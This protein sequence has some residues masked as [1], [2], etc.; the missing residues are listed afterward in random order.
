VSQEWIR[1]RGKGAVEYS[2]T[3]SKTELLNQKMYNRKM[4]D[5]FSGVE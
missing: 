1:G 5:H 3:S 2:P 4:R